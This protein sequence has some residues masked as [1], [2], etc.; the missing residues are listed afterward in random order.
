MLNTS[1]NAER[2]ENQ[3]KY[4][5]STVLGRNAETHITM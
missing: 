4:Q 5:E 1:S 3:G 2:G